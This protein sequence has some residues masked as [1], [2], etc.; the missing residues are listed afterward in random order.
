MLRSAATFKII[1]SLMRHFDDTISITIAIVDT[2]GFV[3]EYRSQEILEQLNELVPP[4]CYAISEG[5]HV[6]ANMDDDELS[7]SFNALLLDSNE[8][9][10]GSAVD[11]DVYS[12][13]MMWMNPM[14]KHQK[15][16]YRIRMAV[17]G[18]HC[19]EGTGK[20]GS[21]RCQKKTLEMVDNPLESVS[22]KTVMA[23]TFVRLIGFRN[24]RC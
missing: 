11:Y 24:C 12:L 19:G 8:D 23:A 15:D 17:Q 9:M 4:A 13:S 7:R 20:K 1:L 3:Q 5:K 16:E 10:E 2:A 14:K 18:R 21:S 6:T 22:G